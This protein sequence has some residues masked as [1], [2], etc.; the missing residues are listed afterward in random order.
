MTGQDDA[1]LNRRDLLQAA[2]ASAAG[3][4]L[5]AEALPAKDNPAVQVQDRAS[6]IR[7]TGV[8]PLR[9]GPTVYLRVETNHGIVGWGE[10]KAVDPRVAVS[11]VES[12]A[13][14]IE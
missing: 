1:N 8:R 4:L 3:A 9:A 11:L 2:G 13:E 12:L 14:L 5:L 6:S 7:I 10:V